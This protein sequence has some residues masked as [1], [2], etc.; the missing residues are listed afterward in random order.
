M[1]ERIA[2]VDHARELHV[3]SAAIIKYARQEGMDLRSAAQPVTAAQEQKVR[4]AYKEGLIDL[5]NGGGGYVS[6]S[7]GPA[8]PGRRTGRCSCCGLPSVY[9]AGDGGDRCGQCAGHY[10]MADEDDARVN[11]RLSDHDERM[12]V[13]LQQAGELAAQHR[14]DRD[15]AYRS[16]DIWKR[17]LVEVAV[18][19]VPDGDG[20]AC[21]CGAGVFPCVT[22]RQIAALNPGLAR[23]I[24]RLEGLHADEFEEVLYGDLKSIRD[25]Y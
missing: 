5:P 10:P 14:G 18:A 3:R 1:G 6:R 9:E 16:R 4:L 7:D 19:H 13:M 20:K 24:E 23:E 25:P 2:V 15:R 22:R 11:A 21:V 17:V 8:T 12:R